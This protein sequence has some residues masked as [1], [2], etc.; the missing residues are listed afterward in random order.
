MR[1]LIAI[2]DHE[3]FTFLSH[4]PGLDEVNFWRPSDTR[5]PRQL[6]A[7]MP[8]IFKLRKRYGGWIVG[9]GIFARHDVQP[10]WLVWE[11][12]EEKNGAATFAEMRARIER[13]R[14]PRDDPRGPSA[15]Y[16]V[17]C[18]MLVQPVFFGREAWVLPPDGFPENSVQG[19]TYDL[20]SG[21]GARV[22]SDCLAQGSGERVAAGSDGIAREESP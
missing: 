13:L 15:D 20:S 22:W 4:Q 2:T 17:G 18:L 11:G 7:G 3:W 19:K 10:I 12:F 6:V 8:V 5:V 9:Y 21:E 14:G 1:G 16:P